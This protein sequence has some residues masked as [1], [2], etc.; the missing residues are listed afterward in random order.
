MSAYKCGAMKLL[1]K[2]GGRA[3]GTR[4]GFLVRAG[5][6]LA[7]FFVLKPSRASAKEIY[8]GTGDTVSSPF[9]TYGDLD[10]GATDV[11]VTLT[12]DTTEDTFDGKAVDPCPFG[13]DWAFQFNVPPDDYTLTD[14]ETGPWVD[15]TYVIDPIHVV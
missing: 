9:V 10:P 11:T 12:S 7:A 5:L 14:E 13:A 3:P 15:N 8:P 4:R 1:T 2:A 6:A